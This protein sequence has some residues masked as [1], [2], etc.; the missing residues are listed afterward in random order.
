M[1][2]RLYEKERLAGAGAPIERRFYHRAPEQTKT[3][4]STQTTLTVSM[5]GLLFDDKDSSQNFRLYPS[6]F[7]FRLEPCRILFSDNNQH[8]IR[9]FLASLSSEHD[10]WFSSHS[11]QPECAHETCVKASS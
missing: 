10:R 7:P 9:N 8:Q 11:G 6:T 5:F 4:S 3:L 1:I 2:R